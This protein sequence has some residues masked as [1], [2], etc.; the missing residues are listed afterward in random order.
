MPRYTP[1]KANKTKAM[2]PPWSKLKPNSGAFS[3]AEFVGKGVTVFG[4]GVIVEVRVG[5]GVAAGMIGVR[6]GVFVSI[7]V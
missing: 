4:T 2:I 1:P 6:V 5:T 7:G 3:L